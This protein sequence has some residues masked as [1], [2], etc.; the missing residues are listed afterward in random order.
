MRSSGK[1]KSEDFL[2]GQV[3][4]IDKE[5]NWTSFD[6]VNKL[7]YAIRRH[8]SINK[9]KVGHAGTLDPLATGLLIICTGKFTKRIPEFMG[10]DKEYTGIIR[11]GS[12]TPTYDLESEID[13]HFATDHITDQLITETLLKFKGE[14]L[15][16][17]PIYSAIKK[18]GQRA[19]ELARRGEQVEMQARTVNINNFEVKRTQND[20]HFKVHCNK[21]TYIRS[22]AHD[23]G[24][25]LKS[26]AHLAELRR[27][28]IGEF[29]V[30]DAS[31][32]H[33]FI[34]NLETSHQA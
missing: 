31:G 34:T 4:L 24:R 13:Q 15:Q 25:A 6:V 30:S 17:P 11:L 28:A 33:E 32:I 20:L 3:L 26:G 7:R 19:Y 14:I 27:T 21:G 5:L 1:L 2:S 18:A 10:L 9:I 29:K 16:K 12:T 23:L 22:L 8:Y